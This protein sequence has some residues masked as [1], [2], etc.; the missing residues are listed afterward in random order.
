MGMAKSP[1]LLGGNISMCWER[2]IPQRENASLCGNW[3]GTIKEWLITR[4][5]S[6]SLNRQPG[7]QK[8]NLISSIEHEAVRSWNCR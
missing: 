2:P 1:Q 7:Q 6:S 4:P 3:S 8:W 5:I